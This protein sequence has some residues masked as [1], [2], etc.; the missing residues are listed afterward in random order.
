MR[1]ANPL[2]VATSAFNP[3]PANSALGLS[4][5]YISLL[6]IMSGFLGAI[7][8]NTT[9]DAALGYGTT[10]IGPKWSQRMPVSISRWH[11]LMSKWV[12]ALV[13]VPVLTGVLLLVA[14]GLL[15]MN[16]PFVGELWLFMSFAGISIAAGTLALFAALGALG[17]LI[18]LLLFVYLALASSGGTIPLQALPSALRFV[19][20]FEPLRQILDGVRAIL[21][22]GAAGDAGLTR[23]LVLTAIGLVF[24]VVVGF[25]VT[26]WYDRKGLDRAPAELLDFVHQSALAYT[27]G[28]RAQD[29]ASPGGPPGEPQG[30]TDT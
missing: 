24:W 13:T 19:A 3:L 7:L 12:V 16:A 23:G 21:Y 15:H 25:A 10:E 6:A 1:A 20:N 30:P 8:I 11:T 17:Q 22:F 9:V 29:P 26:K 5:F 14:V 2:T 4:A 27:G 28:A 18:A